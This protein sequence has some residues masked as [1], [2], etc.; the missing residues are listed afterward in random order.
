MRYAKL[1]AFG[2]AIVTLGGCATTPKESVQLS[3][4]LGGMI[5]NARESH[6]ALIDE[7]MHLRHE[8]VDEFMQ[9]KWIPKYMKNFTRESNFVAV[10]DAEK[11]PLERT[12]ILEEFQEQASKDIAVQ[13]AAM[14]DALDQVERMLR[15]RIGNHYDQML[16]M[17]EVLTAHLLSATK[18]TAAKDEII[19]RLNLP[20]DKLVPLEK[21]DTVLKKIEQFEGKAET[22][23]QLVNEAKAIITE[24]VKNGQ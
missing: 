2:I 4:E 9:Q 13:R 23:N 1:L 18:V 22:I 7:Y 24:E 5:R 20:I 8:R 10:Y 12:K 16:I 3:S 17:N 19:K 15:K 11:N 21:F 14:I 6:F